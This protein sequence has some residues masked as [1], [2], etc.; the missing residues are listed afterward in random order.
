MVLCFCVSLERDPTYQTAERESGQV[1]ELPCLVRREEEEQVLD[2]SR[3][4]DTL[5]DF[6][7]THF[8]MYA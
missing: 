6:K 7:L 3:Y 5:V 4:N 2:W 1:S 8:V